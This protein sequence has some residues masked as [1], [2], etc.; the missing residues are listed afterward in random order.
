MVAINYV[1]DELSDNV[2]AEVDDSG[3]TTAE[4]TNEPSL[5]GEL[6]SQRRDSTDSYFNFDAQRSTRQLTSDNETETDSYSYSA[7]GETVA[8]S[9]STANPFGYEGAIGYQTDKETGDVYVRNRVYKPEIARWSSRD[10]LLFVDGPN[11]Y[12][13]VLN[14]PFAGSDASGLQTTNVAIS[15]Y[16]TPISMGTDRCPDGWTYL[17]WSG[18]GRGSGVGT[19]FDFAG[20]I[21]GLQYPSGKVRYLDWD[22]W[23]TIGPRRHG[24]PMWGPDRIRNWNFTPAA[25]FRDAFDHVEPLPTNYGHLGLE[26]R[27]N[28]T[29]A[30]TRVERGCEE[31]INHLF[32]FGFTRHWHAEMNITKDVA[33]R[34][35]SISHR[36]YWKVING[37]GHRIARHRVRE[38][39]RKGLRLMV[40]AVVRDDAV[41]VDHDWVGFF[42]MFAPSIDHI[43]CGQLCDRCEEVSKW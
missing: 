11:V 6:I 42:G 17:G 25:T 9:G 2:L 43:L 22:P 23:W 1:W 39:A 36:G 28:L 15:G 29:T 21:Y 10:P 13:Y 14:S 27:S 18:I 38:P 41:T 3:S 4:Y 35:Q 7:F 12:S 30:N 34:R 16:P 32:L 31:N 24:I 40:I 33:G 5:Y 37:G 19:T 26:F 8:S 20:R